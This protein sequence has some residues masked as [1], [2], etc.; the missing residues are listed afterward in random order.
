VNDT[1]AMPTRLV[2]AGRP[3]GPEPVIEALVAAIDRG[4]IQ[5]Q[6]RARDVDQAGPA[7]QGG[8]RSGYRPLSIRESHAA[9]A[10]KIMAATA[11][12]RISPGDAAT[13]LQ[14]AGLAHEAGKAAARARII[15]L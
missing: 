12:G 4:R 1:A 6:A 2:P 8:R 15:G 14:N 13:L 10:R 11:A 3:A 9:A 7:G 5:S